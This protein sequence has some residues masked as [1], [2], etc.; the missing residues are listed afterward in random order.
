MIA[1]RWYKKDVVLTWNARQSRFAVA[2]ELFSSHD[3]DAGSRLLLRSLDLP[4]FP[5]EGHAL[6]YGCGYGVLGLAFREQ[7]PGWQVTL[8]DRDALAV[9]FSFWNADRPGMGDGS[10]RCR[11]G[12][13]VDGGPA[14]GWDLVLWNVPGKAGEVPP[15]SSPATCVPP[16]PTTAWP[17]WSSSTRWRT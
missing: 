11:I 17:P 15:N 2:Q 8:V 9:G 5:S 4:S 7:M 3:V 12:L 6:D 10:V 16:S 13:G 1:E 14:N